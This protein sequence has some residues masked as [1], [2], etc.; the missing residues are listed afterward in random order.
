[1]D[2]LILFLIIILFLICIFK[3]NKEYFNIGGQS[4]YPSCGEETDWPVN[5]VDRLV[6]AAPA[7]AGILA[8]GGVGAVARDPLAAGPLAVGGA[9]AGSV[10]A[11]GT[12]TAGR[13]VDGSI[14]GPGPRGASCETLGEDHMCENYYYID[15]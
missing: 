5:A 8:A 6:W 15:K 9:F 10:V 13:R 3:K 14:R 1:M 11:A 4:S 12:L 2:I 7:A